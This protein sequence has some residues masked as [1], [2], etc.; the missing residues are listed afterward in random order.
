M[1]GQ[2]KNK[3]P[4]KINP[5]FKAILE[6]AKRR[7]SENLKRSKIIDTDYKVRGISRDNHGF[8]FGIIDED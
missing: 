8:D 2:K 6:D 7:E 3:T 4:K 5:I 1:D